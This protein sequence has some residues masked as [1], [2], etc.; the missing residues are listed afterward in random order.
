MMEFIMCPIRP[1]STG[2]NENDAPVSDP[3]VKP[4]AMYFSGAQ[5]PSPRAASMIIISTMPK[6][7]A[8]TELARIT[9]P[10]GAPATA[11]RRPQK[12]EVDGC[13]AATIVNTP[14]SYESQPASRAICGVSVWSLV[15]AGA[16]TA[17]TDSGSRWS[18]ALM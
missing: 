14:T 12:C 3:R 7:M 10:A 16:V 5:K 8:A 11:V 2:I 17:V 9:S 18:C 13:V 1:T 4:E 6:A 15:L